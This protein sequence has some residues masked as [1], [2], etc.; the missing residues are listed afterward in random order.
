MSLGPLMLDLAGLEINPEER[1]MLLHPLVGG[2]ILFTRN[3]ASPEQLEQLVAAIHGVREPHLL[4]AV[5]HEG[6]RVQRFR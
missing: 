5:D 1:E 2:V 4:V 3:Y 6:G